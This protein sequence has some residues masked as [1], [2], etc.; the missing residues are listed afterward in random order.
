MSS[1]RFT[2][3]WALVATIDPI[4]AN[5]A[6]A[7]TDVVD[8]SKYDAL[9]AVVMLGVI[10]SSGTFDFQLEASDAS[11]GSYTLI[12]GKAITQLDA[13]DDAKQ[14]IVELDASEL[15]ATQRYVKG[16][17]ANSAH[18]QLAAVVMF[19]RARYRPARDDDLSSV[20]EIVF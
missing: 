2:D 20:D 3:E 14:A 6:D 11:A 8:M 10:A 12:T 1:F 5:N 15:S 4:D 13:N 17:M 16:V 18:S 19:G 9:V 7:S